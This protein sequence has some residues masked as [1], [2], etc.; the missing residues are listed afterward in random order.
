MRWLLFGD[1]VV[2]VKQKNGL[3]ATVGFE[4]KNSPPPPLSSN[5]K[6]HDLTIALSGAGDEY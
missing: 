3:C 4:A 2:P 6:I 5:G 1:P